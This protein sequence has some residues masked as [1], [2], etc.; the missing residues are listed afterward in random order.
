MLEPGDFDALNEEQ[1]LKYVIERGAGEIATP[2]TREQ[3][4][5]HLQQ[6]L[7][8]AELASAVVAEVPRHR[9]FDVKQDPF[10]EHGQ[11]MQPGKPGWD[12]YSRELQ[13]MAALCSRPN[14]I[15]AQTALSPQDEQ[16]LLHHLGDLGYVET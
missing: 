14:Y 10:E 16:R 9:R 11:V 15:D 8:R 13:R 3:L 1:F 6:G 12:S 7:S 5:R 4:R 2:A